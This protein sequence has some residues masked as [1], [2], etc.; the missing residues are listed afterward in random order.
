MDID[1]FAQN[2]EEWRSRV[3]ALLQ[4]ADSVQRFAN[5]NSKAQAPS[6]ARANVEAFEVPSLPQE[7]LAEA[8]E[9]LSLAVEEL[10]VAKEELLQQNQQLA[11]QNEELEVARQI[12]E[13]ER[14]K[15]EAAA[16]EA[17]KT[18]KELSELKSR[19]IATISHEYH[20][21]LTAILSSAEI[22]EHYNDRL[23]QEKKSQLLKLIQA[24]VSNLRQ[25]VN[26]VLFI[27]QIEAHTVEAKPTLL[28]LPAF[29]Q[30]LVEDLKLTPLAQY[31]ITFESQG[32]LTEVYLDPKLLRQILYNLLSNAIKYSP[33]GSTVRFSCI[34]DQ[35]EVTFRI[36]DEGIGIPVKDLP[37]LMQSFYR[38]SNAGTTPGTG[39]G[40]AIVKKCV[41][42]HGGQISVESQLGVGT[43]FTVSL[44][45][46]KLSHI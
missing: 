36:Q 15:A 43:T 3:A 22:L 33:E 2:I 7:L 12:A 10:H 18:E 32:D 11:R 28:D 21:P 5:G 19:F 29:C 20:T 41:D 26:D 45:M 9:E 46:D 31:T 24:S 37:Q 1:E 8:Y 23:T 27:N 38:C 35:E 40:L 13:A 6:S 30:E 17:L 39:L 44:P 42:L 34:C 25:L 4:Q 16:R 14:Q